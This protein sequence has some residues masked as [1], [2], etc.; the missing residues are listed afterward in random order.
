MPIYEYVC[1]ACGKLTEV[2]QK[3]SD[4]P[5]RKCPECGERKLAKL[6]S[7]TTFQLTGGGW[8]SDLYSTPKEKKRK[9]GAPAK[10]A[11]TGGG[12]KDAATAP[13]AKDGKPAAS[14]KEPRSAKK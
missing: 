2:M 13:A 3:M 6:V 14:V 9:E 5:L 1:E 7:R 10:E 12:A 4:P 8:Y 11:G